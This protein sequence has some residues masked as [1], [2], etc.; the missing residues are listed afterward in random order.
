[1]DD[2]WQVTPETRRLLHQ[3]RHYFPVT[4]IVNMEA[5][6]G[7]LLYVQEMLAKDA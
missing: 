7:L 6:L 1:V 3:R 5:G 4:K 2:Q